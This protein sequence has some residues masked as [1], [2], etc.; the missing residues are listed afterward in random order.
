MCTCIYYVHMFLCCQVQAVTIE[1]PGNFSSPVKVTVGGNKE[2]GNNA[3]LVGVA[4][5]IVVLIIFLTI[6]AGLLIAYILWWVCTM[7]VST[8]TC[9]ICIGRVHIYAYMCVN[10]YTCS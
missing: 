5:A 1:G 8:C 6:V 9:N 3:V 2:S 4:L 10:V 7:C